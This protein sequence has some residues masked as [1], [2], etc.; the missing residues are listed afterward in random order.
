MITANVE[1][2]DNLKRKLSTSWLDKSASDLVDSVAHAS[3]ENI[4]EYGFGTAMTSYETDMNGVRQIKRSKPS[5]GAPIWQGNIYDP[6]HYR[7]YLRE[8]HSIKKV[9]P[10][11]SQVVTS[12]DFV[13]GLMEGYSTNW[14]DSY[15]NPIIFP[16]NY[17]HK[18]AVDKVFKEGNIPIIWNNVVQGG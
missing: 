1:I 4:R 15:G 9:S 12:A 11:H 5:G 17:Y 10:Y 8:L 3:L 16:P 14:F 18:R 6:T 13:E 7:G 2:S